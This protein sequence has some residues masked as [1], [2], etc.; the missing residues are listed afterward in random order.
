[1]MKKKILSNM[2][3]MNSMHARKVYSV[4]FFKSFRIYTIKSIP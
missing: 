3:S 2:E 1:M 4:I